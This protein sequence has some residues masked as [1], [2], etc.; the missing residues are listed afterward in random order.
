MFILSPVFISLSFAISACLLYI[1][2]IGEEVVVAS[3]FLVLFLFCLQ[4]TSIFWF[5]CNKKKSH[6][7]EATVLPLER[8]LYKPSLVLLLG[9]AS[10]AGVVMEL[11][12]FS[13]Y[14]SPL[15]MASFYSE[16]RY[17]ESLGIPPSVRVFNVLLYFSAVVSLLVFFDRMCGK[18]SGG[19][20]FLIPCVFLLIEAFL[21]GTKS[22]V[23]LVAIYGLMCWRYAGLHHNYFVHFRVKVLAKVALFFVLIV[24]TVVFVH[25]VRS[26]GRADIYS[27]V[28]KVFTSYL[29]I[30]FFAMIELM[31]SKAS[32]FSFD[33]MTFMGFFS[34][35]DESIVKQQGFYYFD[36]AGEELRTNVYTAYYYLA[37][38]V[39]LIPMFFV[40]FLLCASLLLIELYQYRGV[41]L[42][43]P[44]YIVIASYLMFAFADPIFKYMTN[45]LVFLALFGYFLFSHVVKERESD[46]R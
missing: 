5:V 40:V 2:Y 37:S 43:F 6:V 26:G 28:I 46:G 4:M 8:R 36:I 19:V 22:I 16:M 23:V 44:F 20:K 29:Y 7:E 15:E 17:N 14:V 32:L 12:R 11:A 31:A 45:I 24:A 13:N 33:Y 1:V 39:G 3:Y 42:L 27:L 25:Y 35:I 10:G 41:V 21:I 9:L 18:R 38:D 34:H 30:P